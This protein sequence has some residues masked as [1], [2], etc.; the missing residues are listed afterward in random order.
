MARPNFA[1]AGLLALLV[2]LAAPALAADGGRVANGAITLTDA[3][4]KAMVPGAK[5]GGGAITIAN[6]GSEPDRLLS[7]SSPA[8]GMV[9]LHEMT[10]EGD[11]MRMR[12]IEGGIAIPPGGIVTLNGAQHLMF[13][14]VAKPFETG[15]RVPVTLTF[16]KAGP[17]ETMFT[18][19]SAS[20][21]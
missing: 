20:G 6:K 16:E 12:R 13:M 3:T 19:G 4:L 15:E 17:V 8:A 21:R 1:T 11:V 9:E 2:S 18:V 10:M 5:V 14:K 7:V